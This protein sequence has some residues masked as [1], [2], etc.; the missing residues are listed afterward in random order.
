MREEHPE[1]QKID[2]T[3][4]SGGAVQ[5]AD[6]ED[7]APDEVVVL[8][9]MKSVRGKL[10]KT[11][12]MQPDYPDDSDMLTNLKNMVVYHNPNLGGGY[13]SALLGVKVTSNYLILRQWNPDKAGGAD[14]DTLASGKVPLAFANEVTDDIYYHEADKNPIIQHD[15]ILRLLP[16]NVSVIDATVTATAGHHTQ[17]WIEIAWAYMYTQIFTQGHSF[18]YA[19]S[20]GVNDGTYIVRRAVFVSD[21]LRIYYDPSRGDSLTNS[22]VTGTITIG[23]FVG[24]GAWIGYVDRDYFDKVYDPTA[25][26][27]HYHT[28][29]T[30]PDIA[31]LNIVH[32]IKL[33]DNAFSPRDMEQPI[34]ALAYSSGSG[35]DTVTIAGSWAAQIYPGSYIEIFGNSTNYGEWEVIHSAVELDTGTP[36]TVIEI[37]GDFNGAE[38]EGF[39]RFSSKATHEAG[40]M[41]R[42]SATTIIG[43]P[44]TPRGYSGDPEAQARAMEDAGM[45]G[46]EIAEA[47]RAT[48]QAETQYWEIPRGGAITSERYS[49]VALGEIRYYKFTYIYDG[50]QESLLSEPMK[51]EMFPTSFPAFFMPMRTA[52]HN[53]RITGM[54]VYRSREKEG[55]YHRIIHLDFL[56]EAGKF[57]RPTG[58][59]NGVTSCR[60]K[61]YI[62]SLAGT[63]IDGDGDDIQIK[64][65]PRDHS[66]GDSTWDNVTA[67]TMDSETESNGVFTLAAGENDLCE[68]FWDCAWRLAEDGGTD[69]SSPAYYG[70]SGAYAGY[71]TLLYESA[72]DETTYS[73]G[74][75]VLDS[76]MSASNFGP[77][78]D[79]DDQTGFAGTARVIRDNY[80]R[81]VHVAWMLGSND[82]TDK[83]EFVSDVESFIV[84]IQEGLYYFGTFT[85]SYPDGSYGYIFFDP[86]HPR[87]RGH[88]LEGEISIET[89][90]AFARI[91]GGSL[92]QGNLVLDPSRE[93]EVHDDWICKSLPGQFDVNPASNVM[94]FPDREGGE[95]TG[96]AELFGNVI[97]LKRQS[98]RAIKPNSG[99]VTE[100]VHNI[101]NIAKDGYVEGPDGL[102]I[103][104]YDGIYRLQ[105]NNLA[106]SDQTPLE[107]MRVSEAISNVYD[108]M[109]LTQKQAI[110]AI[111]NQWT[112]EILYA[113]TYTTGGT[114]YPVVWAYNTSRGTWREIKT[115]TENGVV[116]LSV[117]ALDEQARVLA[118]ESKTDA[119]GDMARIYRLLEGDEDVPS[120]QIQDGVWYYVSGD[121]YVVTYNSNDYGVDET[122]GRSFEGESGYTTYAL[123]DG[124]TKGSDG[125][126]VACNVEGKVR[127]RDL[128]ASTERKERVRYIYVTYKGPAALKLKLYAENNTTAVET[129]TL[130]A[131]AVM[132]TYRACPDLRAKK[133]TVEICEDFGTGYLITAETDADYDYLIVGKSGGVSPNMEIG[134]IR[135]YHD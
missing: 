33:S 70:T 20:G 80:K 12:G 88:P 124:A 47:I 63:D 8:E 40:T 54:N 31:A 97:V 29:P 107:R 48:I 26:F 59:T 129:I 15:G 135:I 81:A 90:G 62:P 32:D 51:V 93:A 115:V 117:F 101:G 14:W 76:G 83:T 74:V 21:K 6:L 113:F 127:I 4:F 103:C 2:I 77:V 30:R 128:V 130:P 13:D 108:A 68:D 91:I 121:T 105:P 119:G 72:L 34:T 89:N 69:W 38:D 64:L 125:K 23:T 86:N 131:S 112:S 17:H 24:R 116:D 57:Q 52:G 122:L 99:A 3:D 18:A 35:N 94:R 85:G 27:Y 58:T 78:W 111:Y 71:K 36:K 95:I 82:P 126:L 60:R 79:S 104:F 49:P 5:Y 92:W 133:F 44:K 50:V 110:K 114:D 39:I 84:T 41:R 37:S 75:V 43:G 118:F 46:L 96:I 65:K 19:E 7:L 73:G 87:G 11:F 42:D 16:G 98:I 22:T 61:I 1:L 67:I 134:R 55:P 53:L 10:V 56:R 66:P 25:G 132:T 100:V 109:D 120:G 123:A 102:Y 45:T 106:P 28:E 9:N